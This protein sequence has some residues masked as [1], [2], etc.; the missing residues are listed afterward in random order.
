M[1]IFRKT[2]LGECKSQI[3]VFGDKNAG[4][5]DRVVEAW[6]RSVRHGDGFDW[7]GGHSV[8]YEAPE[9]SFSGLMVALHPLP[10]P[11]VHASGSD[12]YIN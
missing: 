12:I 11:A 9:V 6:R 8:N 5:G 2:R 1:E 3:F 7:L 4:R 10:T